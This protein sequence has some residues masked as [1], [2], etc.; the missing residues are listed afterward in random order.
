[1]VLEEWRTAWIPCRKGVPVHVFIGDYGVDLGDRC[2]L[3]ARLHRDKAY[4]R[5]SAI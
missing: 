4:S 3:V 2:T 1:M 5:A